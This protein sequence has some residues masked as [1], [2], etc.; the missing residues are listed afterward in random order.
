[1]SVCSPRSYWSVGTKGSRL[2]GGGSGSNLTQGRDAA[3]RYFSNMR[4]LYS[5]IRLWCSLTRFQLASNAGS[6]S[7]ASHMWF[8][9]TYLF[10][11]ARYCFL[12]AT[13]RDTSTRPPARIPKIATNSM[14]PRIVSRKCRTVGSPRTRCVVQTTRAPAELS[15]RPPSAL[16][17]K[18]WREGRLETYYCSKSVHLANSASTLRASGRPHASFS[19]SPGTFRFF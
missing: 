6:G 16:K 10:A 19:I 13:A 11:R 5:L 8:S 12:R 9:Q 18:L 14:Q 15:P 17:A 1:M 4:L 7:S 3:R 2:G